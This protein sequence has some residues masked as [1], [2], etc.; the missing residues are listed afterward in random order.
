MAMRNYDA[1]VQAGSLAVRQSN[2][3]QPFTYKNRFDV[4][5]S[6]TEEPNFCLGSPMVSIDVQYTCEFINPQ[7]GGDKTVSDQHGI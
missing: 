7:I 5:L 2:P 6:A 3:P 4:V 1:Y